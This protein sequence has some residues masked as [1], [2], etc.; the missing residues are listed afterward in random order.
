MSTR[1]SSV[2]IISNKLTLCQGFKTKKGATALGMMHIA[3]NSSSGLAKKV[4]DERHG[5][6]NLGFD[7]AKMQG[8]S[9]LDDQTRLGTLMEVVFP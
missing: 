6:D 3:S 1:L 8:W 7:L 5:P 9:Y 4:S 2:Y